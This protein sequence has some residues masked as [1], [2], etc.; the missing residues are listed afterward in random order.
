LLKQ[1]GRDEALQTLLVRVSAA[2]PDDARV[3]AA[4]HHL[5]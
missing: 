3:H 1:L 5:R 2:Q 4:V